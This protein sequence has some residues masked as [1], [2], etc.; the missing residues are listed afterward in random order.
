MIATIM[1]AIIGITIG[2]TIG[3]SFNHHTY[4]TR[5]HYVNPSSV[6]QELN[7]LERPFAGNT[8][9]PICG[10]PVNHNDAN[11]LLLKEDQYFE[12]CDDPKCQFIAEE[13]IAS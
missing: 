1:F 11:I 3:Y 7:Q 2:T 9:C 12:I 8:I 13:K 6:L 10:E 5:I 4:T